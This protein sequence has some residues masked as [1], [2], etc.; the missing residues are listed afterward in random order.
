MDSNMVTLDQAI[1]AAMRL[2][3]EQRE[4]LL[5]ILRKRQTEARRDR[6]AQDAQASLNS[7]Q[8]GELVAQTAGE[9][10]A[11][12]HRTLQDEE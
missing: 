2:P 8:A 4:M 1:D 5:D 3:Y 7:F 10:V 12:L 11:E 6:M 9:V